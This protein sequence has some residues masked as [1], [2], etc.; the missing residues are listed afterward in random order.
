[1]ERPKGHQLCLVALRKV[2]TPEACKQGPHRIFTNNYMVCPVTA[3]P[4]PERF[5]P[6]RLSPGRLAPYRAAAGSQSAAVDLYRWNIAVSAAVYE[7]LHLLEVCCAT[8][9]RL[10]SGIWRGRRS[11]PHPPHRCSARTRRRA[12]ARPSPPTA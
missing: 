10:W 6:Q 1:M 4:P 9:A 12:T 2:I 3:Q 5:L 7:G 11:R 8:S